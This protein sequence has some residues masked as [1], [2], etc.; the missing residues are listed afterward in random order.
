[1]YHPNSL[2]ALEENR[3]KTQFCG[4]SAVRAAKKKHENEAFFK[5]INADLRERCTPEIIASINERIIA[6]AMRGNLK[7]YEM[8][9]NGLG[10]DPAKKLEFAGRD[11]KPLKFVWA[12]EEDLPQYL[13]E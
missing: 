1:M 3:A 10:E 2:K 13:D 4:E 8:I 12:G 11:G 5:S 6:L 7:A 9:R